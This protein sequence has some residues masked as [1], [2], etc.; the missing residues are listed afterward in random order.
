MFFSK[1]NK[2]KYY[3]SRFVIYLFDWNHASRCYFH[4]DTPLP[5]FSAQLSTVIYIFLMPVDLIVVVPLLVFFN[6]MVAYGA[7]KWGRHCMFYEFYLLFITYFCSLVRFAFFFHWSTWYRLWLQQKMWI[8]ET[9]RYAKRL[10]D[11]TVVGLSSFFSSLS[12]LLPF[13]FCIGT[14]EQFCSTW[15]MCTEYSIVSFWNV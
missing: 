9:K 15:I 6:I 10:I 13:Y 8:K 11:P 14:T 1:R 7:F 12:F 3:I 2:L 4:V 5:L